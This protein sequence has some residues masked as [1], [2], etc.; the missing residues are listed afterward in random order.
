MRPFGLTNATFYAKM[1]IES[2]RKVVKK[3]EN[4]KQEH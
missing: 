2:K 1:Y 3:W 4:I